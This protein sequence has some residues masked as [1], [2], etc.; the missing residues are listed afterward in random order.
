MAH[1]ASC[2]NDFPMRP[3]T[4]CPGA[5]HG[6][7]GPPSVNIR[8]TVYLNCFSI[9]VRKPPCPRQLIKERVYLGPPVSERQESITIPAENMATGRQAQCGSSSSRLDPQ[10]G[11]R[12]HQGPCEASEA[13]TIAACSV[14]LLH[15][16]S[17]PTR[18]RPQSFPKQFHQ[19]MT[20]FQTYEPMGAI[21]IQ[22]TPRSL[23]YTLSDQLDKDSYSVKALLSR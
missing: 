17:P 22:T 14:A 19:V 21:H 11:H 12:V 13:S 6:G 15:I 9:A 16:M 20:N 7:V 2:L 3:S 23:T 18:P 5:T 8:G 1:L 10:T 4:I